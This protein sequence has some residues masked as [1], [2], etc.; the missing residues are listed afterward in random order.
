V[1]QPDTQ[2]SLRAKEGTNGIWPAI[3]QFSKRAGLFYMPQSWDMGQIRL[4]Y[5]PFE[6]RHAAGKIRWLRSGANPRSW[7]PEACMLTTRPPKHVENKQRDKKSD[8]LL[9][10]DQNVIIVYHFYYSE[11]SQTSDSTTLR[12][13]IPSVYL[14]FANSL[15]CPFVPKQYLK[16]SD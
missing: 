3:S 9:V 1:Y 5:F 8:I 7:V 16:V 10:N 13:F 14:V 4:F 2:R 12:F 6:G 15:Y 11:R